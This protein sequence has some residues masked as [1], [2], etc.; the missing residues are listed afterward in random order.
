MAAE[1]GRTFRHRRC[2]NPPAGLGQQR[3]RRRGMKPA[4]DLS[5]RP[6]GRGDRPPAFM[7]ARRAGQNGRLDPQ[8]DDRVRRQGRR[9]R[10]RLE[11]GD[12]SRSATA[13]RLTGQLVSSGRMA[14][15]IAGQDRAT[16]LA[17][18]SRRMR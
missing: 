16:E 14:G 18:K 4:A 2:R 13:A 9:Q 10:W 8:Q 12:S 17:E 5:V 15:G 7:P 6:K 3:F 11:I 1:P